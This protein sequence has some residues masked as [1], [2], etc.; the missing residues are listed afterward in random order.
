LGKNKTTNQKRNHN[1]QIFFHQSCG[2]P[3]G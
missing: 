2:P 3:D 1:K